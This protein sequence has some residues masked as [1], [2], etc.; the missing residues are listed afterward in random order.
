MAKEKEPKITISKEA[1][2]LITDKEECEKLLNVVKD[3]K[4]R[5]VKIIERRRMEVD[6]F[7]SIEDNLQR[8]LEFLT[9]APIIE[10]N[11]WYIQKRAIR[12][13]SY[14]VLETG[15]DTLSGWQFSVK[16]DKIQHYGWRAN[17]YVF[18]HPLTNQLI[19]EPP[20]NEGEQ[21]VVDKHIEVSWH[22]HNLKGNSSFLLNW[23]PSS[24][25]GVVVQDPDIMEVRGVLDEMWA[26]KSTRRLQRGGS[27]EDAG[28]NNLHFVKHNKQW[29]LLLTLE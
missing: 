25:L 23:V 5:A 11:T 12:K 6:R 22:G 26:N 28:K 7:T 9:I 8:R 16:E 20:M 3:A 27:D 13:D 21:V 17:N 15:K 4:F 19:T 18:L 2:L 14:L 24:D 10:P 29:Y 1:A